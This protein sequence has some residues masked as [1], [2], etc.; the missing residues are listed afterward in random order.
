[1]IREEIREAFKAEVPEIDTRVITDTVLNNWL[2]I[3][4]KEVCAST[5][6]ILNDYS[7]TTAEDEQ[8]WNILEKVPKFYA[9]DDFP[10][11]GVIFDNDPLDLTTIAQLDQ[12]YSTWRTR[13]SGT[14]EY[15]FI[16]G[17]FLWFDRPVDSAS[18]LQIY[19]SEISDDFNSDGI[20]P[21]NQ[22]SYLEP[23][24]NSL[25]LYL[26][27]RA[28]SKMNKPV[29]AQTA[30]QEFSNYIAWMKKE[31]TAARKGNINYEPRFI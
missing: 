19:F 15:Y 23:F 9:I 8:S 29:E 4:D 30:K 10:G 17:K 18:T 22:L 1:M 2:L 24:H 3:G 12:D 20:M 28:K 31:I 6:C 13:S 5:R 14:P 27:Y 7:W 25:V 11:G 26:I 16:R 21:F